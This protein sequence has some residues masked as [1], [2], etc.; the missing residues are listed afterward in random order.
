MLKNKNEHLK[1]LAI[2]F[3]KRYGVGQL[4]TILFIRRLNNMGYVVVKGE[5]L[6]SFGANEDKKIKKSV[7]PWIDFFASKDKHAPEQSSVPPI[8]NYI[9]N[10][11][12]VEQ[13][14]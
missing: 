7:V 6:K 9:S 10:N 2:D 12:N 3:E 1:Q 8:P 4:A 5:D 13:N 11:S 14:R